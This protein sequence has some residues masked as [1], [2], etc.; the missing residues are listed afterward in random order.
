MAC[1]WCHNPETLSLAPQLMTYPERCIFCFNC[2]HACK[3]GATV[4]EGFGA[5]AR[6]AF[7]KEKCVDCGACADVC[8]TGARVMS[9]KE[10][11]VDE[12][13]AEVL[14]DTNYYRNSEGGITVSG[15]EATVQPEFTL[16]IL[17]A[18][19]KAGIPTAIETN[20]YADWSVFERLIPALDLV[21]LDIKLF[22]DEAH[23][24]WVGV[25]NG[26]VL[27]NVKKIT[28]RLPTIIR[29]PV[30]PGVNDSA[31]EIGKIASF[32]KDLDN[33]EYYELLLYNPLGESKYQALGM[34]NPFAGQKPQTGA[35]RDALTKAAEACGKTVKVS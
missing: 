24:K 23:R 4:T 21:M 26:R 2:A 3:H 19:K 32:V 34:E 13:M 15:G 33:V 35:E 27:E 31:E 20:M 25:G 5:A 9:G 16:A 8:Y 22:D 28:A 30:I 10:M 6:L 18:C 12:V 7:Y 17:E 29:T 1:K 11:S 14:Q